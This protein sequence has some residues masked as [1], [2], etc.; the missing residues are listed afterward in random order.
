MNHE[1]TEQSFEKE[2][3]LSLFNSIKEKDLS[4][5]EKTIATIEEN[6]TAPFWA[7]QFS[8]LIHRLMK[9]VNFQQ[10]QEVESFWMDVMRSFIDAVP[11]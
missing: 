1:Q 8:D 6:D 2:L 7:K 9:N 11:R 10:T 5:L 3:Q 4:L